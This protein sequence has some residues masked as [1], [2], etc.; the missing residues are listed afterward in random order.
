MNIS[1]TGVPVYTHTRL[2][3]ETFSFEAE[4][5]WHH[6]GHGEETR[7]GY[8]SNSVATSE[9]SLL[10]PSEKLHHLL[11]ESL[12]ILE[13]GEMGRISERDCFGVRH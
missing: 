2:R 13:V 10:T 1:F 7:R 4:E 6:T 5:A 9:L 11:V 12:G 3:F 8:S